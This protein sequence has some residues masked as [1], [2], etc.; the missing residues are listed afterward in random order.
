M[1]LNLHQLEAF[2]QVA[3]MGRFA[4]AAERMHLSQAGLSILIRKLEERLGV[5]LFERT[6]RSVS[7]TSAGRALLPAAERMLQ[8]A[9]WM[10]NSGLQL[11]DLAVRRISVA[12]PSLFAA[13]VLPDVLAQFRETHPNVDV[14]F[15]ECVRE[16]LVQRVYTRDVDFAIGLD[17]TENAEIESMELGRDQISI[18]HHAEHVLAKLPR[19]RWVDVV[20]HPV[21]V[22]APGSGARVLAEEAF[23]AIKEKLQPAYETSNHLTAVILASRGLGVAIV[24]SATQSMARSMGVVVRAVQSPQMD[25]SFHVLKRRGTNLTGPAKAFVDTFGKIAGRN[26]AAARMPISRRHA[27]SANKM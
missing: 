1:H 17:A 8:D 5:Q 4:R 3:R 6:S 18:A 13:T 2:V 15:R 16:E 20:G 22:I 14:S 11:A 27:A 7:L 12:L 21:I 23:S 9:Q 24:S 26:R 10:L 19:I 25:R